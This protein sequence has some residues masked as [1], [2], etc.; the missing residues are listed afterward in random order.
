MKA[1]M[2]RTKGVIRTGECSPYANIQLI[3]GVVF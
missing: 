2:I 3:S 1:D